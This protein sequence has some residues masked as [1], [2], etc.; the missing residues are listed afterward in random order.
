MKVNSQNHD[1]TA[2][3]NRI[4]IAKRM[5][6]LP[7]G[8]TTEA[9]YAMRGKQLLGITGYDGAMR[10]AVNDLEGR[11]G[12]YITTADK[13]FA[14]PVKDFFNGVARKVKNPELRKRYNA[15]QQAS[16]KAAEA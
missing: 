16:S 7:N 13:Y 11:L 15:I 14:T 9:H 1:A 6:G 8:H 2:F 10:V 4:R 12:T 5:I 3:G